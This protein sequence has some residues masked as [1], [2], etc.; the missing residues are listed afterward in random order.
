MS[1][2]SGLKCPLPPTSRSLCLQQDPN[3]I[4]DNDD[5]SNDNSD[6][7]DYVDFKFVMVDDIWY[8]KERV[9]IGK[10]SMHC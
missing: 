10:L 4:D 9:C 1:S 5:Y 8:T 7:D 2:L 3:H 6:G